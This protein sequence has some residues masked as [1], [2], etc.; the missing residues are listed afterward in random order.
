ME[1]LKKVQP[2]KKKKK[3]VVTR[4]A[5]WDIRLMVFKGTNLLG[6]VNKS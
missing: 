4:G 6:A 3:M 5:W 2:V 1:N